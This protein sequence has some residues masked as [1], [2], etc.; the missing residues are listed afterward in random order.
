MSIYR[1]LLFQNGFNK[2][3]D[4][5]QNSLICLAAARIFG[6]NNLP[7]VFL[8]AEIHFLCIV[9]PVLH[10]KK[11]FTNAGALLESV[12]ALRKSVLKCFSSRKAGYFGVIAAVKIRKAMLDSGV[13]ALFLR[14]ASRIFVFGKCYFGVSALTRRAFW[15]SKRWLKSS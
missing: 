12:E 7:A 11:S 14:V 6:L 3:I 2:R 1:K 8:Y 5:R 13:S 4:E 9:I 10:I 15:A